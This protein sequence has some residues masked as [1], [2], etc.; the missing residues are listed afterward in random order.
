[1]YSL[2]QTEGGIKSLKIAALDEELG[3][4]EVV[5]QLG[6]GAALGVWQM[7]RA[8]TRGRSVLV[9]VESEAGGGTHRHWL[10]RHGHLPLLPRA[11]L[12]HRA[13]GCSG[14]HHHHYN[15]NSSHNNSI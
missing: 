13:R 1:M 3:Q 5:W 14:H 8:D 6:R 7:G 12:R 11:E 2:P 9:T 4:Y 15:N 10:P